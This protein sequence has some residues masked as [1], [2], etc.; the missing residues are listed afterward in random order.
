MPTIREHVACVLDADEGVRER[1]LLLRASGGSTTTPT[2]IWRWRKSASRK[3]AFQAGGRK[4]AWRKQKPR[5]GKDHAGDDAAHWNGMRIQRGRCC[6][7]RSGLWRHNSF[8]PLHEWQRKEYRTS[9]W[10]VVREMEPRPSRYGLTQMS[11]LET[12]SGN[13]VHAGCPGLPPL[14]LHTDTIRPRFHIFMPIQAGRVCSRSS[15]RKFYPKC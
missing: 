10:L 3:R 11:P 5:A 8:G 2:G 1:S 6:C 13:A 14:F 15:G 4:D 9:C 12:T 7:R